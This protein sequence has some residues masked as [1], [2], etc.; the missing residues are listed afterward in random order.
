NDANASAEASDTITL[1]PATTFSLSAV[2][3]TTH[4]PTGLPIIAANENLTILGG[5]STIERKSSGGTPAFRLFDVA[6]GASLT[7]ENVTL[8]GGLDSDWARG[9]AVYNQG[10]LTL[11]RVTVQNNT[12]QGRDGVAVWNSPGRGGPAMGGGVYSIGILTMEGCTLQNNAALGGKGSNPEKGFL[13]EPGNGHPR[14]P[15]GD[16]GDAH[17]GGLYVSGTATIRNCS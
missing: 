17:G 10:S 15:G 2:D 4:G 1:A 13:T 16:G 14:I 5:A 6:A 3:N 8:Q 7:L 9:G 11:H 12:A